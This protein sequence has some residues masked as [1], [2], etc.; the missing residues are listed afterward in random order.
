MFARTGQRRGSEDVPKEI[1]G[2]RD[3]ERARPDDVDQQHHVHELL[4]VDRHQV[5][6]LAH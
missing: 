4:R 6:R 3:L 2:E 1:H 5:C